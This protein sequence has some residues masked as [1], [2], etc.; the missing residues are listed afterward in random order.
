MAPPTPVA[1][2]TQR[3]SRRAGDVGPVP[4]VPARIGYGRTTV[5]RT[6]E[7]DGPAVTTEGRMHMKVQR[8]G[9]VT[10][11]EIRVTATETPDGHLRRFRSEIQQGPT[12]LCT[13][14][15]VHGDRL[16]LE[17]TSAGKK[18]RGP[19]PGP[20]N[21]AGRSPRNSR[22]GTRRCEPGE[23]ARSRPST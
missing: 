8:Y 10:E 5:R 18:T 6:T 23:H 17:M 4:H 11:Q 12:P 22:C 16:E 3:R 7:K 20:S 9:D 15:E 1:P 2:A 14:G 21:T 19:C 13:S